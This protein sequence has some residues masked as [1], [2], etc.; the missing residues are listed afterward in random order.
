MRKIAFGIACGLTA[1]FM[2]ALML[3]LYGRGARQ[4]EANL[5][6]SQA[7][8]ATLSGV[9][10]ENNDAILS[11]EDFV[12]DFLKAFLIQANSDSDFTVSVLDADYEKG[13]LS[14]EVVERFTHPNGK[15]GAVSE[16]RTVIFDRAAEQGIKQRAVRY[17]LTDQET[18]KEYRVKK[19][20]FCAVPV[21]PQKEGKRF[22]HWRFVA[23][24]TGKAESVTVSGARGARNVLASGGVPCAASE[25][26]KLIAVFE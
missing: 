19:G 24:G 21:P 7:I 8:D 2:L 23:G 1:L 3:T 22:S 9:M 25:D 17:C 5:A 10:S 4:Q 20:S 18:Y 16:R 15:K 11:N 6:L 12:A 13:L 26:I 14:V